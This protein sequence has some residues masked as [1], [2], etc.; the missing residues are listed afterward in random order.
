MMIRFS[1]ILIKVNN[2]TRLSKY[3]YCVLANFLFC[4]H[5]N[6]NNNNIK[7]PYSIYKC[8]NLKTV[9]KINN[10]KRCLDEMRVLLARAVPV[11]LETLGDLEVAE[12]LLGLGAILRLQYEAVR[13]CEDLERLQ[14]VA[15]RSGRL[16]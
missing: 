7:K 3:N 15:I 10:L 9:Y 6:N 13:V 12:P 4:I 2:F 5:C 8:T 1:F 11:V 14:D 16:L